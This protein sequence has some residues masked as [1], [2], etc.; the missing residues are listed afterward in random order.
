MRRV[1]DVVSRIA[2]TESTVYLH[3]ESGTGKEIVAKVIHLASGEFSGGFILSTARDSDPSSAP[4]R[5][6][7]GYPA[8]GLSFYQT[9]FAAD[10]KRSQ[11]H[12]SSGHAKADAARLAGKYPRTGELPGVRSGHDASGHGD[13]GFCP[14]DQAVGH[15]GDATAR[16]GSADEYRPP[17]T[18]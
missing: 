3:G 2:A 13:R 6:Q 5:A 18:G 1:L 14:S 12:Y 9:D 7:R 4:A 8:L 11:G 10:E 15:T 16:D 17:R